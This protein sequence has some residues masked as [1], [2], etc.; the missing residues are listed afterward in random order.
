MGH[1]S[2]SC[3]PAAPSPGLARI[4]SGWKCSISISMK[5]YDSTMI[6]NHGTKPET[7]AKRISQ[8]LSE[9]GYL[10]GGWESSHYK[11]WTLIQWEWK[12]DNVGRRNQFTRRGAS[13]PQRSVHSHPQ[14]FVEHLKCLWNIWQHDCWTGFSTTI[15]L[16]LQA[17]QLHFSVA[18][19][20]ESELGM[21]SSHFSSLWQCNW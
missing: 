17:F 14:V 13:P 3:L 20:A 5:I 15:T 18:K 16:T 21:G 2:C 10:W 12:I 1:L 7:S 4:G 8:A 6:F 11:T 9:T 19:W